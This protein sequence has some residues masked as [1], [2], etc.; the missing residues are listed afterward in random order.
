MR[1]A[2]VAAGATVVDLSTGQRLYERKGTIPRIPASVEK[3]YTTATA[4]SRLGPEATLD[5]TVTGKGELD[6]RGV[7]RGDLYLKGF[8]DPSLGATGIAELVAQV[9]G[10]GIERV[11]GHVY[12]DDSFFDAR[13]GV[14]A[15]AYRISR[16]VGPLSALSYG[17]TVDRVRGGFQSKPPVYAAARLA[18]ALRDAGVAVDEASH[19]GTAPADLTPIASVS[20]P[21]LAALAQMT[22]RPSDNFFAE[23]LLK[24]LGARLADEGSTSAGAGVVEAELERFGIAPR[25]VDGSGLSR[26]N[27]TTPRAVVTL[28]AQMRTGPAASA[29]VS[30]LSVVG[31][32]GTL[33]RRMRG[34]AAQGHCR[35]KT[36]TLS[37]VSALAG[38]C[39]AADGRTLAFA[40]LMNRTG[41]SR[42]HLV[43]D[44]MTIAL[45][46]YRGA[47]AV[48]PEPEATPA[49][50]PRR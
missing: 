39:R 41:I 23:T 18:T 43:Q 46:R 45:A 40:F 30:S 38:Y 22:N 7:W 33:A 29:F 19:S 17:H 2:G 42:A 8:G 27:R 32:N 12:G 34:S 26:R 50:A 49:T 37:N 9:R 31:E 4:L 21:P 14:P 44:R 28:L 25:I 15:S 36:G 16:Y 6:E 3:L 10:A 13:R 20:S 5:T 47:A 24:G 35:G 11:A 1:H 48:T